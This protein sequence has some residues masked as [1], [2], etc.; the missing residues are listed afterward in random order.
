MVCMNHFLRACKYLELLKQIRNTPTNTRDRLRVLAW[1]IRH[2]LSNRGIGRCPSLLRIVAQVEGKT[3]QV[4]L[5]RHNDLGVFLE[6]FAQKVYDA[7]QLPNNAS[8]I[9]DLGA[10]IGMAAVWFALRYPRA[11]IHAFEPNPQT[12]ACLREHAAQ[13]EGRL[14]PH[15]LGLG[16]EEGEALLYVDEAHPGASLQKRRESQK[17]ISVRIAPLE[18]IFALAA[19]NGDPIDIVKFDIEGAE[20]ILF[21][22]PSRVLQRAKCY[23]GEVH[24]DLLQPPHTAS[25]IVEQLQHA[26]FRVDYQTTNGRRAILVASQK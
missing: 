23:I 16:K 15:S 18:K 2:T 3:A 8:V 13:F 25:Q 17:G 21:S 20:A 26:G 10:N 5:T 22:S 14:V 24:E 7:P 6:V 4:E 1:A 9:I 19:P 12:F 11:T